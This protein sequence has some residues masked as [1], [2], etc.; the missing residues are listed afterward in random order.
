[1]NECA[2][3]VNGGEKNV[4]YIDRSGRTSTVT[5]L[6][7][8]E[9]ISDG[10]RGNRRIIVNKIASETLKVKG[11]WLHKCDENILVSCT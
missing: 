4:F 6:D 9:Q 1:M 3:K 5:C 2:G 10:V 7:V 8:R 11:R